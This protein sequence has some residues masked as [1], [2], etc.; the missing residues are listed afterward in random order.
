MPLQENCNFFSKLAL[1]QLNQNKYDAK[2]NL[3]YKQNK[4][5]FIMNE[6][7]SGI[8]LEMNFDTPSG[9]RFRQCLG[10]GVFNVLFEVTA[11]GCELPDEEA[12]ARLA[13]LEKTALN[14]S[15][16]AQLS[17]KQETPGNF[18]EY[19]RENPC[20]AVRK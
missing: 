13:V 4:G 17:F 8:Q 12:A 11:P 9:N 16:N 20:N 6:Q 2:L 3:Y 15:K 7:P 5:F 18:L 1:L 14:S 10:H 19:D